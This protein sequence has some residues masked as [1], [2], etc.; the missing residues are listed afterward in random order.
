[1]IS[2]ELQAEMIETFVR[3]NTLNDG[4]FTY[5]EVEAFVRFNDLG[6]PLAQ[7]VEFSLADLTPAGEALVEAT[8]RNMC[9]MLDVDPEGDYTELADLFNG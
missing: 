6:V 5:A 7:A 3:G 2:T 9:F 8:W 4:T 1:M